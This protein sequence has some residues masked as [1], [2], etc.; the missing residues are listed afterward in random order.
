M[1]TPVVP[2]NESWLCRLI[3]GQPHMVIGGEDDPY[4]R[5]WYLIPRNPVINVYLHQFLRDD[6]RALHDHPWWFVSLILRGGYIEYGESADRKSTALIRSAPVFGD[7]G[8]RGKSPLAFR[9]A[10]YRHRVALPHTPDG[11]R[12]PCWTLIITG[13]RTR[14]WGFWCRTVLGQD[15]HYPIWSR[16]A[17]RF[18]AWDEFGDAGC[19]EAQ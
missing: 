14:T 19:G 4:L 16:D 13:R 12:K 2:T 15:R 7:W 11:G 5:R 8:L 9:P 3:S 17:D 18:I 6:D 1:S 10:T